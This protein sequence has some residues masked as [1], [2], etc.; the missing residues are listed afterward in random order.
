MGG[1][2]IRKVE[3]SECQNIKDLP[4]EKRKIDRRLEYFIR[5]D[6]LLK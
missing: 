1:S 3:S 2:K 4:Q 5:M 6:L